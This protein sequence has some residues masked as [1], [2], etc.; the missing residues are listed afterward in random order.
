MQSRQR[1]A[2]ELLRG[3]GGVLSAQETEDAL[4]SAVAFTPSDL[5]VADYDAAILFGLDR[6]DAE[7][8]LDIL[9]FA[10]LQLLELRA[11]DRRLDRRINE[12]YGA[13]ALNGSK[14][15]KEVFPFR[16]RASRRR[17]LSALAELKLDS[18]MLAERLQNAFKIIGDLYYAR[19][20]RAAS[21]RLHLAEWEAS[22]ERK[23]RVVGEIYD[24]TRMLSSTEKTSEDYDAVQVLND[25]F[26]GATL[27]AGDQVAY[28]SASN[29]IR[30][31]ATVSNI[32][33]PALSPSNTA[34]QARL[35][36]RQER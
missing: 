19:I 26:A 11:L 1:G 5:V 31:G 13:T 29:L 24:A 33:S 25:A 18:A 21:Q 34:I 17:Q 27:L 4:R 8:V 32:L 23:L 9:E 10:N 30:G 36:V 3:E 16:S 2:G 12:L 6:A 35:A 14:E 7:D 22:S 15:V 28:C 20:Y